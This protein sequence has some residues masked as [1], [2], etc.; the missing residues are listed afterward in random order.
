MLGGSTGPR[1]KARSFKVSRNYFP[2]NQ[3]NLAYHRYQF[4][5]DCFPFSLGETVSSVFEDTTEE[6]VVLSLT[7]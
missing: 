6:A 5:A 4:S 2:T 1:Q 3:S 7:S